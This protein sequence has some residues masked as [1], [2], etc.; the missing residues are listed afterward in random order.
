MVD[1]ATRLHPVSWGRFTGA[2]RVGPPP[3]L[4][5]FQ[6]SSTQDLAQ[7]GGK[8]LGEPPPKPQAARVTQE[9]VEE[10]EYVERAVLGGP[11]VASTASSS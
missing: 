8:D 5:D 7:E 3:K 2:P 4:G 6:P 9:F 11:R 1:M 10:S